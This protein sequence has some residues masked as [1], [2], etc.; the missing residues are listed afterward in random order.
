MS[1]D[2]KPVPDFQQDVIQFVKAHSLG[3]S[4][5]LRLLDLVSEIGEL[6]KELLKVKQYGDSEFTPNQGW[7]DELGDVFFSLIC[8]ANQTDVDLRQALALAL[9]KYHERMELA[10]SISSEGK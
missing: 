6:A 7:E 10:G 2:E 3:T 1:L 4:A 9:K 8:L 5:E